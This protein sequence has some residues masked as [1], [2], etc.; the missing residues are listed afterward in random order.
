MIIRGSLNYTTSG[1]RKKQVR[2]QS[3]KVE[4]TKN[5][6]G[7]DTPAWRNNTNHTSVSN[8]SHGPGSTGGKDSEAYKEE[9][10]AVSSKYTIAPAY[11]KGAYQVI[12]ED[13]T[14]DIGR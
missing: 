1:R 2:K 12:G 10:R 14:K 11:N 13:G 8:T 4:V 5:Y 3:K 9:R 6:V 7:P